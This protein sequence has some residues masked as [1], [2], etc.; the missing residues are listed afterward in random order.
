M[1]STKLDDP[2]PETAPI[3]EETE[4]H[5]V[6]W[7]GDQDPENPRNWPKKKKWCIFSYPV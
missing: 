6:S 5:E 4:S 1:D 3:E 7:D 2:V